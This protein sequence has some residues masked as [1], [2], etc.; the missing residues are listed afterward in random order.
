MP[1]DYP[2]HSP[3]FLACRLAVRDLARRGEVVVGLSG[4]PDS[5]AL[6][7]ALL[8]EGADVEAVV[9]DHGLQ[10]GSADVAERAAATARE[11]G[12]TA[13]VIAV[14]VT[15]QHGMEAD[16]RT[17][18]YAA[19]IDAA[20]HRPLAVGH[21]LDDQAETLLLGALR[22]NPAGMAPRTETIHRPLL[23]TRRAD[24]VG[25]CQELGLDTWDDPQNHDEAFR[26][27]AIRHQ[28]LP[29]L[30]QI[31]GGDA[32]APLAQAAD[33]IAADNA[34]LDELAGA[35]TDDCAELAAHPEPI[36]HRRIAAFLRAHEL[37]VSDA[38]IK[39]VAAL[40]TQWRGQGGVAAGY[41]EGR[42]LDV[43]RIGGKL[44][45]IRQEPS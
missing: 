22:G 9:I 8:V 14:A 37:A 21:T 33:R 24:T 44:T 38:V 40:C 3:H 23:S 7:A 10:P 32:A 28:I 15:P 42:R 4:G 39:A 45:V 27:V 1:V 13:R 2:R 41:A 6:T 29:V 31:L 12:A 26:R 36:R 43:Q 17:A 25:A 34:Y 5:L 18:R 11:L 30:G 35:P 19:L 16:A 20:G